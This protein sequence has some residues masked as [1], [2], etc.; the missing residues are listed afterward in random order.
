M[1]GKL[2][3]VTIKSDDVDSFI[4]LIDIKT[5]LINPVKEPE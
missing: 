3:I 1:P 2:S 4:I 5:H